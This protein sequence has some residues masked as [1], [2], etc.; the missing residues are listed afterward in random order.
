MQAERSRA[1]Q[2]IEQRRTT[3]FII[4]LQ[5]SLVGDLVRSVAQRTRLEGG[6]TLSVSKESVCL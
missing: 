4:F 2:S 6:V 1:E 5:E 3:H